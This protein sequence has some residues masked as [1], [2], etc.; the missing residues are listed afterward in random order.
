MGR[1]AHLRIAIVASCIYFALFLWNL[2]LHSV[3]WWDNLLSLGL[4]AA[5]LGISLR[6]RLRPWQAALLQLPLLAH[7]IGT[8]G[9]AAIYGGSVGPLAFDKFVHLFAT[10]AI[11]LVC[12]QYLRL[13]GLRPTPALVLAVGFVLLL[14]APMEMVE[15]AGY[16]L[17]PASSGFLSPDRG[18]AQMQ[19]TRLYEDTIG[20]LFADLV[21]GAAGAAYGLLLIGRRAL[22]RAGYV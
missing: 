1:T 20:D 13:A 14:A 4:T 11:G 3:G 16:R 9:G 5:L 21:G 17:L 15:Y 6:M 18:P 8:V 7:N 2:R 12:V 19:G 10:F 22:R